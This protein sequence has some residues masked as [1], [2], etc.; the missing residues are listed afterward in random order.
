MHLQPSQLHNH[1]A[2]A[3]LGSA[4]MFIDR[5]HAYAP[6]GAS[7][8]LHNNTKTVTVDGEEVRMTRG[9]RKRLARQR[10]DARI[11]GERDGSV[12]INPRYR[13]NAERQAKALQAIAPAKPKCVRKPKAA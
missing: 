1:M 8:R 2:T 9:E 10:G 13:K 4:T 3:I 7:A 5:K 11:L 12:L 6:R